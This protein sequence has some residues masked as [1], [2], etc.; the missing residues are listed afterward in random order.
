MVNSWIAQ[1][2]FLVLGQVLA[3]SREVLDELFNTFPEEQELIIN[4]LRE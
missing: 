1:N 3:L 2:A 4:N